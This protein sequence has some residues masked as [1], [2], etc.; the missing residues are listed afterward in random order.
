MK[1][2]ATV[3]HVVKLK[4]ADIR[5]HLALAWSRFGLRRSTQ[6]KRKPPHPTTT[7]LLIRIPAH[8]AHLEMATTA[9]AGRSKYPQPTDPGVLGLQY[10]KDMLER[11]NPSVR[12]AAATPLRKPKSFASSGTGGAEDETAK[13]LATG[14]G[15]E[16]PE[17][18]EKKGARHQVGTRAHQRHHR[19]AAVGGGLPVRGSHAL[20]DGEARAYGDVGRISRASRGIRHGDH[21]R[22]SHVAA[23]PALHPARGRFPRPSRD[24]LGGS[25]SRSTATAPPTCC[26][27]FIDA[28]AS[29]RWSFP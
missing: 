2:T 1:S 14:W 6:T 29:R 26:W 5:L 19:D 21:P 7:H 13:P 20:R 22:A 4:I 28:T 11:A 18:L 17:E 12:P 15:K 3:N 9:Q 8:P 25:P 23:S 24:R 16:T 27:R 10:V